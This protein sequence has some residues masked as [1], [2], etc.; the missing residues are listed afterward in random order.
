M[1]NYPD[2]GGNKAIVS[3]DLNHLKSHSNRNMSAKINTQDLPIVLDFSTILDYAGTLTI[4]HWNTG[5]TWQLE[6]DGTTQ[7]FKYFDQESVPL[8]FILYQENCMEW[9]LDIPEEVRVNLAAFATNEF[10]ILYFVSHYNY[11]Y[12]LFVSQP[13]LF[14]IMVSIA[15]EKNLPEIDLLALLARPRKEILYFCDLPTTKSAF[16]LISKLRFSRF[17]LCQ[18]S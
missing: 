2:I 17:P 13:T 11:A 14:W 6:N 12:Q 10:A 15:K 16:N 9:Y 8:T 4:E 7:K 3:K 18:N 1:D 5:I